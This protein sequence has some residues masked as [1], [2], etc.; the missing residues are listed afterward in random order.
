[1]ASTHRSPS[2]DIPR[3]YYGEFDTPISHRG[4]SVNIRETY[5]VHA[6]IVQHTQSP[7][8]DQDSETSSGDMGDVGQYGRS[9]TVPNQKR[10]GRQVM[11]QSVN[12][13][14]S[15][16]GQSAKSKYNS[17]TSASTYSRSPTRGHR[18]G[19]SEDLD[20]QSFMTTFTNNTSQHSAILPEHHNSG[21]GVV[22]PK[23]EIKKRSR[24]PMKKMFGDKGWLSHSPHELNTFEAPPPPVKTVNEKMPVQSTKNTIMNK[25]RNKLDH[26]VSS[27][28]DIYAYLL[29]HRKAEKADLSPAKS[30]ANA[31]RVA[32]STVLTVSLGP[33]EQ[34]RIYMELELML[35][36]TAN[37]FLMSQFSQ[38]RI[39]IDSIKKTFDAWKN[40]GRP[41]VIEF[42]YDQSTQRELVAVN[43]HTFRFHGERAGDGIRINSMLYNWKQ[44]ASHMVVRTLCNA[45]TVILKLIFDI[46]QILEL[47][48]A[49]EGILLRYQN[50]RLSVNDKVQAARRERS[51]EEKL[52]DGRQLSQNAT[53]AREDLYNKRPSNDS[54]GGGMRLVPDSYIERAL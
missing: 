48:G 33:P 11:K 10:S 46:G 40:K 32:R 47:L 35:V 42:M 54:Y 3:Y 30:F 25:L 36:H 19:D 12:S 2:P 13:M 38:G 51:T 14:T 9:K 45:D 43:Q 28:V 5:K 8:L 50:I 20:R 53:Q 31:D 1:M 29:I 27:I 26:F 16:Q 37:S 22:P 52:E 15:R 49:A 18:H 7:P 4:R 23:I 6:P 21:Y 41:S 44:V 17:Q 24:S 39:A 34:A